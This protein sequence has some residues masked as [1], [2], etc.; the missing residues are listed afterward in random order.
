MEDSE[1][2]YQSQVIL[3][4]LKMLYVEHLLI[5]NE[6]CLIHIFSFFASSYKKRNAGMGNKEQL[7]EQI[8]TLCHF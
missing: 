4:P 8:R 6:D 2:I 5:A 7:F 1:Y 3:L